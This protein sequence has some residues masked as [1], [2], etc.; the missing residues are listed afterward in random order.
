LNFFDSDPVEFLTRRNTFFFCC[1]FVSRRASEKTCQYSSARIW[2]HLLSATI[3][4]EHSNI[5][6]TL[7]CKPKKTMTTGT[8][9][10]TSGSIL[11]FFFFLFIYY[12]FSS[13]R[14]FN[15]Y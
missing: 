15:L 6:L 12:F 14:A 8:S 1:C 4:N 10:Q 5:C 9:W 11:P 3:H 2:F 13:R 7:L